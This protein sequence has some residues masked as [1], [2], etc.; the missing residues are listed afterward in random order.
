MRHGPGG[1]HRTVT[2]PQ[3]PR[4]GLDGRQCGAV[5]YSVRTFHPASRHMW[6]SGPPGRFL[7][8]VSYLHHGGLLGRNLV[9]CDR[10]DCGPIQNRTVSFGLTYHISASINQL[11]WIPVYAEYSAVGSP[12]RLYIQAGIRQFC[13][14]L[15]NPAVG[16]N[17]GPGPRRH[18]RRFAQSLALLQ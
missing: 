2:F 18:H 14:K 1:L 11:R 4:A 5:P 9:N 16:E 13:S 12:C 3:P 6:D 8:R 15:L 10:V 7:S 17:K